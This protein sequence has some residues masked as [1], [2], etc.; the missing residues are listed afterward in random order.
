MPRQSVRGVSDMPSNSETAH[1]RDELHREYDRACMKFR[2]SCIKVEEAEDER[3]EA[4][5]EC[6]RLEKELGI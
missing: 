5:R 2:T 4:R 6:E 1:L 3:D